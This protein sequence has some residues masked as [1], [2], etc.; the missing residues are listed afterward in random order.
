[1][2]RLITLVL[3][4]VL[5]GSLVILPTKAVAG[6]NYYWA[7]SYGGAGTDVIN[8]VKIWSDGSIIAVGYTNSTGAG[9]YDA[10][11]MKLNPDGSLAWAKT[12]GGSKN[13]SASAVAIANNG[14]IIVAGW[15]E[16]FGAGGKDVWV[17]KLDENGS[18][19]WQKTYGGEYDDEAHAVTI[20]P[21]AGI[22][23]AG[24]TR[25]FRTNGPN[26]WILRLDEN[27]KVEWQKTYGGSSI[28]RAYAIA[29][30]NNGDIIVAGE[31]WSFDV[32]YGDVWVLRLDGNGNIKWQKTYGGKDNDWAY[33]VTIAPNGDIILVGETRS[34]GAGN[35]D[36]WILRLDENGNIKWQ[37]TYGGD[38]YD[39]A[40]AV[41]IASNGDIII[42]GVT[43]NFGA[44]GTD[45]WVLRLD[46]NGNIKWE[47]IYGGNDF[48]DA[49]AVAIMDNGNI[50]IAGDNGAEP[51]ILDVGADAWLLRLPPDGNL[52]GC[53]F[54]K[55]SN[56]QI[57]EPYPTIEDS[58]AEIHETN[59]EVEYSNAYPHS[60]SPQVE[61]QYGPATLSVSSEPSGAGVYING[62]YE[63][64][65]PLTL[66]LNPGTYQVKLSKENYKDYTTTVTLAP[67]ENKTITAQL[68]PKPATLSVNSDPAGAKVYVNGT[69][70]GITPLNLTLSPGTYRIKLSKE[71]YENY[72][73]TITLNP[74]ESKTISPVLSPLF[75]YLSI[76]SPEGAKV[77]V[78]GSLIG[79]TPITDYKLPKGKHELKLVKEG[80]EGYSANITITGGKTLSLTPQL[81][82]IIKTT[83]STTATTTTTTTTTTTSN[84][85]QSSTSP[86]STTPV[87]SSSTGFSSKLLYALGTILILAL[88]GGI[89]AKARGGKKPSEPSRR[90][91]AT[92][93]KHPAQEHMESPTPQLAATSASQP[94]NYHPEFP[95]ELLNKYEPLE[96]LGEGGFAKVY[97]V[98]RKKDGQI[99]ALKIPRIDEK[100]SKTFLREVSTWLQLDHP[101]IVKLYDADIL[102][103]P[104]LEMEY[105]EGFK[106][107]GKTIRDLEKYPK[108]V[109]ESTALRLVRG[110][111]EGL[112]HAHSKG[113][114]HRDLKP[115]NVLLKSDLT[116]KITDWGLAKIGTMSS[117][118]S[119][120]GYTPL[121][122]APEHL[123]PG[124]YG[125]TD[126]RTDIW[127]LGVIFYELLTGKLPFEGYTYEEVFGKIVDETYRFTP[128]S[129]IDPELAKYDEIFE[130]L[131]AKRKEER[132]Q[133]VDEFLKDVGKLEEVE[134]R[135][136]ELESEV[137]ELK[138]T[139]SWSVSALKKSTTP[140]EIRK[141]RRIVVE[142]LGKL[143]LAYAQL[144]NKAELLNTLN[145]LKFYTVK[146]LNDL[147]SAISTAETLLKENLP[148][149]ED[150]IERLK[151]LVHEIKRENE[152]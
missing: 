60:W 110:I 127:Q 67:M 4:A 92:Q 30:A 47:K 57:N 109:D 108:P 5:V 65:T 130:K 31:T 146:N 107:N 143:A 18:I 94:S 96:F 87:S 82:P 148:V 126:A 43:S 29:L 34:F 113:I 129:K 141:N 51:T 61:T 24:Y 21:N 93:G 150:F 125:H 88:I 120:M 128:P 69:Y 121:Y 19:K 37:K 59:A 39:E 139:L 105:V 114:Y 68:T 8:D 102:P 54:Y 144:N 58:N 112:K 14:D 64:V 45:V 145:D 138:K 48:D 78:D 53:S 149:S 140:E 76:T 17:L 16:S 33:A 25:S 98:R 103:V 137:Q 55:D 72:T 66:T 62:T 20:A 91:E 95:A 81:K 52:P 152:T 1:M 83:T 115:Q 71:D 3:A 46:D 84:L 133:S 131:L 22:I 90:P 28:D 136:A 132:Y 44:R 36:A 100:T 99:V 6:D 56:A 97:K 23:V 77:Y 26:V 75:G 15:T 118:R 63:G 9:G 122:A 124:K 116:P 12:Y 147:L 142:T 106:L 134:R 151:V 10:F 27:G 135:K 89:A 123:L 70:E 2:R 117:S 11:V 86:S 13:D 104:H 119:V 101:N 79:T 74:G 80:Y 42:A 7:K 49:H 85:I 50:I 111:A 40:Y 41:A 38:I 35:N 32:A 73:T